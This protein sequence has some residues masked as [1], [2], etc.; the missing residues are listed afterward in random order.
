MPT[1]VAWMEGRLKPISVGPRSN[2]ILYLKG[3]DLSEELAPYP[4]AEIYPLDQFFS[5]PFFETKKV[6]YLPDPWLQTP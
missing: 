3:G 1:F 6:V 5:E 4:R 2:G